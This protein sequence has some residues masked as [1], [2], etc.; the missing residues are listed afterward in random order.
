MFMLEGTPSEGKSVTEIEEG[1]R[2]Q[3]AIL[4]RDGVN[5][6]ELKR[7]TYV[8]VEGYL[9]TN[10]GTRAAAYKSINAAKLHGRA[11]SWSATT[12]TL[13]KVAGRAPVQLLRFMPD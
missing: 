9:L 7:A 4:K 5:E 10:P 13:V 8:Y 1:L 3:I 11:A 6:D 12:R 2:E